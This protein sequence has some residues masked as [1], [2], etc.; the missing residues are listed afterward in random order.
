M[1]RWHDERA[2]MVARLSFSWM[3][4]VELG[5]WRK[6]HPYDCGRTRCGTCHGDKAYGRKRRGEKKRAAIEYSML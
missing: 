3:D 5:R 6:R 1:Q 4:E 2:I